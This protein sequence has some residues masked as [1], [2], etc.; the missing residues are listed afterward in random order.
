[1]Y[2]FIHVII[3]RSVSMNI[4]KQTVGI[5][6]SYKKFDAR[7]GTI[8]TQQQNTLSPAKVFKNSPAGFKLFLRWVKKLIVS[9]DIPLIFVMEATGVYYEHLAYFLLHHGYQVA[10]VLPN[11]IKNYGKSLESKSK[12]DPL[13]AAVITRFGLERQLKLWTPP[14]DALKTLRD[15]CREYHSVKTN[16]TQMKNQ[17][18]ALSSS[19]K[20]HKE[21]FK[22]KMQFLK[23]LE[24]QVSL[25]KK[26]LRALVKADPA[27]AL[28]LKQISTAKG[29]GE[30]T[31]LTVLAETRCFDLVT[32]QKQL[33]SYAGLDVV[34]NDSGMKK[35]K[36]SI[37]KKGNKFIRKALFMP[38]LSACRANP[39]MKELYK[40]LVDKGK[41]KKVAI[42]AVARKLLLLIYTLWKT[43]SVYIPNYHSCD[44][45]VVPLS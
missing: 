43:N 37:S 36:T 27:L 38:A 17:L 4:L 9:H 33:T 5:D 45:T 20:P 35:G 14:S 40:R 29:L 44:A 7:F 16:I 11:K 10:V 13:D 32:N 26:E 24:R 30:I 2:L 41:N 28:H 18:H 23:F 39:R 1:M 21:S 6:V 25:I 34:F 19:F 31:I 22:R 42:I 8:D 12:T 3:S 15:L